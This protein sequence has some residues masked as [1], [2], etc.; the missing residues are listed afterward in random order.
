MNS[1]DQ[2]VYE[3]ARRAGLKAY[4]R[5]V[6]AGTYPYLPALDLI[7]GENEEPSRTA[8]GTM[9]IPLDLVA[10]TKSADRSN[11]FA[12]NFMPLLEVHSEFALKWLRLY[13]AHLEEGI[14][15]A[16]Q[17]FE[18]RRRFY[19]QE[20]NKRVSVLKY[21]NGASVE[22]EV[23]RLTQEKTDSDDDRLYMEFLEF[24]KVC[25]IYDFQFTEPGDYRL[26]AELLGLDLSHPWTEEQI[27]SVRAAKAC[28]SRAFLR[29][30]KESGPDEIS[31][32]MLVYLQVFSLG[33]LLERG[34]GEIE[35]RIDSLG[36]EFRTKISRDNIYR[37]DRADDLDGE[38]VWTPLFFAA[39]RPAYTERAP[40]RVAFLYDKNPESSSWI[41]PHELGRNHVEDAFRGVVRTMRFDDCGRGDLLADRIRCA[42]EERGAQAVFTISPVMMKE[43]LKSAIRYPDVRFLNCSVN[44]SHNAVRTYYSRMYEAKFLMGALASLMSERGRIGYRA[45]YPI[46]GTVAGINA[47]AIG[48]AMMNP[49]AKVFLFWATEEECDWRA[50]M[51]GADVDVVSGA[52]SIR[53][54]RASR[55]YGVFRVRDGSSVSLAAPVWNWG[56]YYELIL[57]TMLDGTYDA[58][59]LT[60]DDQAVNY[61][62][63]MEDGVIDV[64]LS[65]KLPYYCRKT[66]HMLRDG[67][68]SGSLN[69]FGG[70]LRAQS[71]IIKPEGSAPLSNG[72]IITMNW[73]NDNVIGRIPEAGDLNRPARAVVAVSGVTGHG[74]SAGGKHV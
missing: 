47:F 72:E 54:E 26:F 10:G 19:V 9:E 32:A 21:M 18:Y 5:A 42:V 56:R 17:V 4:R 40:L 39:R 16:V 25:P 11:A 60:R 53:P 63:G 61:Y 23:I 13:A 65:G 62:F 24:F 59:A 45:D 64:V 2:T 67:I 1:Y 70:E 34:T 50:G 14:R 58:R 51:R 3:N 73:L 8:V 68:R 49:E 15:D 30:H 33:S 20:G 48:A 22:A 69:P 36:A 44:L 57:K 6:S 28:F 71:G 7:L 41:Y 46:Y 37:V 66:M 29:R 52:D 43:S 12:S 74:E 35:K 55:E 31:E 27:C 38:P